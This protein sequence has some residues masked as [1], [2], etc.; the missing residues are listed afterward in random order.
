MREKE[1]HRTFSVY[2][3]KELNDIIELRLE[4]Y[5][6]V[7]MR[8]MRLS[9]NKFLSMLI[10]TGLKLHEDREGVPLN[11]EIAPLGDPLYDGF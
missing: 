10:E 8:G 6:Q 3:Y 4:E 11:S 1:Q 9:K 2:L 7:R 5:N